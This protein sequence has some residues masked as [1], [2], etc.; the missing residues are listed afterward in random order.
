MGTRKKMANGHSRF[1]AT[2]AGKFT[3]NYSVYRIY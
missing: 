3:E 1:A 2:I